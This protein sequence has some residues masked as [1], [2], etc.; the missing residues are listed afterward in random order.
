NISEVEAFI[1]TT[2]AEGGGDA[3]E[4]IVGGLHEATKLDWNARYNV[5]LHFADAPG[6]GRGWN[7]SLS[8]NYATDDAI[9]VP[10]S[11]VANAPGYLRDLVSKKV[12]YHFIAVDKPKYTFETVGKIREAYVAA[13]KGGRFKEKQLG[14]LKA[15]DFSRRLVNE[16]V[17]S[18][19]MSIAHG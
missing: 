9:S 19:S 6:H 2:K 5:L 7:C 1:D 3:A 11:R 4:D 10:T 14:D 17:N 16:I 12:Y 15:E 18:I 13:G 8:D